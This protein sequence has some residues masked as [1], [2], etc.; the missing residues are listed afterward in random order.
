[1][2]REE[3]A[4]RLSKA[5]LDEL[6][7][8]FTNTDA[9]SSSQSGK[10]ALLAK[11]TSHSK[12]QR[13]KDSSAKQD[14]TSNFYHEFS[15][16][17]SFPISTLANDGQDQLEY[18]I[19]LA[20][21]ASVVFDGV[22]HV[23]T[24]PIVLD[25]SHSEQLTFTQASVQALT[26]WT[27][28]ED[29][30]L[31]LLRLVDHRASSYNAQLK[32][33]RPKA[34]EHAFVLELVVDIFISINDIQ[35]GSDEMA[36]LVKLAFP[37]PTH[38]KADPTWLY[39]QVSKRTL[40][41]ADDIQSVRL[42]TPLFPYQRRAVSWMLNR[43][44]RKDTSTSM[45]PFWEA[46]TLTSGAQV[47]INRLFSQLQ[48]DRSSVPAFDISGG[49][50]AE[51]MGL[52]KTI[53]MLAL[54]LLNP[55]DSTRSLEWQLPTTADSEFAPVPIKATLI[56]TPAVILNQWVQEVETHSPHLKVFIYDGVPRGAHSMDDSV[57]V[58]D[59]QDC[60]I[61]LSTYDILSRE[62]A[63]SRTIKERSRRH[64]R[65]YIPR[66]SCLVKCLWWRVCLDEVQMAESTTSNIAEMA[67][68][69]PRINSWGV[70]GTPT[71]GALD[72]LFGLLNFL[73]LYPIAQNK[74]LWRQV[75]SQP[76]I[77]LSLFQKIMC[78]NTKAQIKGELTLPT[79]HQFAV[80]V[81]LSDI[82]QHNYDEQFRRA[83][84]GLK[85]DETGKP[86]DN[87]WQL[88]A[89]TAR[90]WLLRLRMTCS[91]PQ[92]GTLN[93][94]VLGQ[95]LKTVTESKYSSRETPTSANS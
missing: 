46:M 21:F 41:D 6:C 69:I 35:Y 73:H 84:T 63:F 47:Y 32:A 93:Q 9:A 51:E 86:T 85:L 91:H 2:S 40:A 72:D 13:L 37:P 64:E 59:V 8:I 36:A 89:E 30:L 90:T 81:E 79:Q 88:D 12:R 74:P 95:S 76:H 71:K 54:V 20:Q 17:R 57:E 77:L 16:H 61:V 48:L 83:L 22:D 87:H 67:R 31:Q 7:R 55:F 27:I 43:E 52:G 50:L 45:P 25:T 26:I 78:R 62:L 44:Q 23:S 75:V 3:T 11:S 5:N 92:V 58:E 4:L 18:D 53:E 19:A 68:L 29:H 34:T 24:S 10:H 94:N 70:S 66:R 33:S 56:I 65:K 1:M 49:L 38:L 15:I 82:E 42:L 28:G 39:S 14:F 80:P 60:D